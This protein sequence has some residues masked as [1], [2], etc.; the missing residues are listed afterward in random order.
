MTSYYYDAYYGYGNQG[1]GG[2]NYGRGRGRGRFRPRK[3]GE[4]KENQPQDN[5]EKKIE[6]KMI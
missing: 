6:G 2:R 5:T 4:N 1:Y 3:G